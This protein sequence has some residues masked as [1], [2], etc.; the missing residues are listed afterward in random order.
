MGLFGS[1]LSANI[2]FYF[3][4]HKSEVVDGF[5]DKIR[6]TYPLGR[7]ALENMKLTLCLLMW[8]WS[9]IAGRGLSVVFCKPSRGR[10]RGRLRASPMC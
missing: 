10:G 4:S 1:V 2:R 8:S 5:A 7:A 9:V 6:A 3:V